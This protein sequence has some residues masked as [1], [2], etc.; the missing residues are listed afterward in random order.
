MVSRISR[1]SLSERPG[2]RGFGVES[3]QAGFEASHFFRG[4]VEFSEHLVV[5]VGQV[6]RVFADVGFQRALLA[7]GAELAPLR[8]AL[9]RSEEG[10]VEYLH[11]LS[12]Q[13]RQQLVG[14]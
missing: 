9:L 12:P 8:A 14:A 11:F 1:W 6:L 3:L 10:S 7:A 4:E 13:S 5:E 2:S